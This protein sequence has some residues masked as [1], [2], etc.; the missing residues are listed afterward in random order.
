[1]AILAANK[2]LESVN[3]IIV[4]IEEERSGVK[5]KKTYLVELNNN[6]GN[7]EVKPLIILNEKIKKVSKKAKTKVAASVKK[8]ACKQRTTA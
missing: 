2:Q 8:A 7:P 3:K 5:D 4:K 6:D 1:M